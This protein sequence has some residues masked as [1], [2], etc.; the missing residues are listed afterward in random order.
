LIAEVTP[1]G[2]ATIGYQYYIIYAVIDTAII[3]TVY[4]CFPETTG[5]SLEEMDEIFVRSKNVFDPPRVAKAMAKEG[6]RRI[7]HEDNPGEKGIMADDR[8]DSIEER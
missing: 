1:V 7:D 3:P 4:F 2:F 6:G 5:R 8:T